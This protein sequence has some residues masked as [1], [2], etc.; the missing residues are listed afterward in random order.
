[1]NIFGIFDIFDIYQISDP[2]TYY[3]V[4]SKIFLT[5][6]ITVKKLLMFIRRLTTQRREGL[7]AVCACALTNSSRLLVWNCRDRSQLIFSVFGVIVMWSDV[8]RDE[9]NREVHATLYWVCLRIRI[10]HRHHRRPVPCDDTIWISPDLYFS[11]YF[12]LFGKPPRFAW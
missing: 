2:T 11:N 5:D 12:L 1:M 6:K 3:I 7:P 10:I 8:K 4:K 9:V